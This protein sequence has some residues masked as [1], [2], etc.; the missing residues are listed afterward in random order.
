MTE[1]YINA[2]T[3]LNYLVEEPHSSHTIATHFLHS[4]TTT[5]FY[6]KLVEFVTH[7]LYKSN[8]AFGC[9]SRII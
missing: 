6:R 1:Y 8:K 5:P 9:Q 4:D 2:T 3:L 7:A